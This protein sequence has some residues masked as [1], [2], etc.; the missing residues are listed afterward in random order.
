MLSDTQIKNRREEIL[1]EMREI[2]QLKRGQISEQTLR[3]RKADGTMRERGPYYTLQ[4]WVEGRNV[5][6]R[7]PHERVP[8]VRQ[9][10]EGYQKLK[11][12]SEEFAELTEILCER[13][14]ALLPSKKNSSKRLS[15]RSLPKPSPSSRSPRSGSKAKA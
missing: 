11:A 14:G 12:L 2:R 5:S 6:Q 13:R 9:A 15:K 3:S 8:E 4:R 10:V 1:A 7:V